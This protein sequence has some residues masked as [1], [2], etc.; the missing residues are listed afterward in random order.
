MPLAGWMLL[1]LPLALIALKQFGPQAEWLSETLT[2]QTL[3]EKLQRSAAHILFLPLA[4]IFVVLCRLTFGIR[5]LG[6]FR[7][8]LLAWAF[9]YTGAWI[10]A[11]LLVVTVAAMVT[12]RKP[13]SNLKLPYFA[14]ISVMLSAV[15]LVP[16][17]SCGSSE[18]GSVL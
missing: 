8:I 13:V 12:L 7:A 16:E 6:P 11:L 4:A 17:N 14:R 15:A 1:L 9:Q 3:P 18:L 10:G 5:V 2:L